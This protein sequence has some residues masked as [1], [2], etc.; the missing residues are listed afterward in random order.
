VQ[1]AGGITLGDYLLEKEIA[2]GGMGVV[3]RA[4]QLS[5]N[6]TVAIKLLL[7]GRYSSAESIERFRREAQ[8]IGALRHPGI[9]A[10]HEVGEYQGQHFISMEYVDGPTLAVLLRGGPLPPERAAKITRDVA[11]AVQYAHEHGVLHR[12]LKPS[13]VLLDDAGIP[14]ITDFGLAK[15]LDG[16]TDLTLTGQMVGTPNYLSPEQAA[17]RQAEVGPA[18]DVYAIGAV[19]YELLTGR[20]PFMA[21]SVQETLL[22]IRDRE[23]ISPRVLNPAIDREIE[24]ICLK[25]LEKDPSR[26]YPSA[27][28][29]AADLDR[30]N[31]GEPIEARP[32]SVGMRTWKWA[33]R[34]PG[35]ASLGLISILAIVAFVS[36]Q[37][38][39]S[40]RLRQANTHLSASLYES[41]WR[42]ADE[43][44]GQ[45]DRDE[46]IAWFSH[47]LRQNPA[48][49]AAAAR[50]LSLLTTYNFPVLL[51]PPL[52][53]ESSIVG[54]CFDRSGTRLLSVTSAG[55]ARFWNL[56]SGKVETELA[57]AAKTE[58]QAFALGGNN[59]SRLLTLS[60]EPRGKLW[61]VNSRRLLKEIM[62]GAL[63]EPVQKRKVIASRD[64]RLMAINIHSNSVAVLDTDS[65][66]WIA[67]PLTLTRALGPFAFSDDKSLLATCAG[68]ELQLWSATN[69]RAV[70]FEPAVLRETPWDLRFSEDGRWLVC[71]EGIRIAVISTV[72]G[73]LER[74]FDAPPH[75]TIGYV[76]AENLI[77]SQ[78]NNRELTLID[79]LSGQ[80]LGSP[81]GRPELDWQNN[82]ALA[83]LLL[84]EKRFDRQILMDGS[85]GRPQ[86][87]PFFHESWIRKSIFQSNGIAVT[88]CEDHTAR[89]W[90][91][92]MS[93][94][95][96]VTLELGG[97]VWDAQWSP[98]GKRVLTAS[99]RDGHGEI[100]LWDP[101]TGAPII[102]ARVI[103][104]PVLFV[105][106]TADGS[107]FVTTSL[108]YT[109]R[110]WNGETAES[111]SPPLLHG[112]PVVDCAF[113]PD[114]KVLATGSDDRTVRFWDGQTGEPIGR[115]L[116]NSDVPLKTRFS[117]D[118]RRVASACLD[119]TVRVWS[120]PDGKLL[121]GP[122]RHDGTCW[123][124]A[125]SPDDRLV[126]SASADGTARL[127]DSTTGKPVLPPIRHEGPVLWAS[128][129]P[130]G[131][132]IAT[133]T[134]SGI[135]RVWS[136][137]T[138]QL[139]SSPMRHPGRVW[140]VKWSTDGK[141]LVTS[142]VDGGARIWDPLTGHLITEPFT[143]QPGK[144]VRRVGFGP[145]GHR[146]LTASLDGSTKIWDLAFLHPPVPV[147]G[148]VPELAE[149][150][151]GKRI[152]AKDLVEPVPG[153]SF[154]KVRERIGQFSAQD[155]YYSRW[156]RWMLEDRC[157]QPVKPFQ[158]QETGL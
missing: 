7:L 128:F 142:C 112:G 94:S 72:T 155:G 73:K 148:W 96:P 97:P 130:D 88:A 48:D 59:D 133:S 18:S 15:K 92:K 120:V 104:G 35:V 58:I 99:E 36:G 54:I 23:P 60:S 122:L 152:G 17:G 69:N 109:S 84:A 136:A 140:T 14:R 129:S 62:L 106:W 100:R 50:L 81:F 98:S 3:Y 93:H 110:L 91:V 67:P 37:T 141:F 116:Q 52:L 64:G 82:P 150:L 38:L 78:D 74:E 21:D 113:S 19:L 143:H 101:Q 132:A 46:A 114:D 39:M 66:T 154:Q 149:A 9:V 70:L 34:R 5:L 8:S 111:I 24:T 12:D 145:D 61:D 77:M 65:G 43:A 10:V 89:I 56:Q 76:G 30:K 90:S 6:R 126:V 4:H 16:S 118:G 87:E 29:L 95:E 102:P 131:S 40:F 13:N 80:S 11:Q 124:A 71:L 157:K 1:P 146:L 86:L 85:T 135:A 138:G 32:C 144:E 49:S 33:R 42:R 20:P 121:V 51:Y 153:E 57:D 115:P 55:R 156:A 25:C 134:E 27:G 105:Q 45:G 26:R 47:F 119:G 147:P 22:R 151:G 79:F 75:S 117:S 107:R 63:N 28:A 53:H 68:Q 41:H 123:I 103:G 2:H 44:S 31:R 137:S 83:P 139:L 158:P 125:F 127:W 108:D